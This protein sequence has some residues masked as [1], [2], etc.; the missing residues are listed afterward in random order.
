MRLLTWNCCAGPVQRKLDALAPLCADVAVI[1]ESPKLPKESNRARWFGDD[2]KKKGLA[3]LAAPGFSLIPVDLGVTLPRYVIP[4]QVRRRR[5][6]F[7]LIA[8][9]AQNDKPDRYVRGV[10][11][12]IG[13]CERII[14]AQP[15]VALGDFNSNSIWDH[16]HP[17]DRSHSALVARLETL[18][19]VSAYHA[20]HD[21][22]QGQETRAT[23]FEYRHENRPY[24]IDFCFIPKPWRPAITNLTVGSFADWSALS[25][26][27]PVVVDIDEK[28]V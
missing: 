10:V 22:L 7:L 3:V 28:A 8:V 19:L 2:P 16:E 17:K 6:R 14:R 21:E 1:P 27:M 25:D 20:Y 24:H 5:S 26:H 23:F 9:W 15:T 13:L 4:L 11:R 18:G 12:A